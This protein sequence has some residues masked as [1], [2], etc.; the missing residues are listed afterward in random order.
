MNPAALEGLDPCV[1]CGFCL[2]SCPTYLVTSDEADSPRGRIVLMRSMAAG[3]LS[4]DDRVLSTHLDRCLGCRA[5]EPVCPSGVQYGHAIEDARR[6]LADVR[7]IPLPVRFIHAVMAEDRLRRPLLSLARL[8]RPLAGKFAGRSRLG[9][10]MGMLA[11][12]RPARHGGR[13][14]ERQGQK[15][16]ESAAHADPTGTPAPSATLFEG[17]IMSSLFGH[18]HAATERVLR[19][20]GFHI[21]STVGQGCCGALHAHAGQHEQALALA[22]RNVAAFSRQPGEVPIVVN[23]AGCGAMLKQY[24]RLLSDDPMR[25]QATAFSARV[26]DVSEVLAAARPCKGAPLDLTV[27]YDPPC[28]LLHAQGV[29]T[30]PEAIFDAVPGIERVTHRDADV[31]CGSA[32][33][34]TFSQPEISNAVLAQK[35]DTLRA[36]NPDVVATG[37]P[38]CIMQIGAGLRAAG[39]HTPVVHPIELLDWSYAQAGLYDD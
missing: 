6:V 17:C 12:S 10:A 36:S 16:Q 27:A 19:L 7:P 4:A 28:H 29:A 15:R 21:L 32:G 33:S 1:H 25:D 22:C 37:N 34:F 8:I 38:G 5:C 31:C 24:G 23:A 9:F 18:V 2:Q 11:A 14:T 39:D 20:N 13:A 3:R 30:E 35:I 26:R